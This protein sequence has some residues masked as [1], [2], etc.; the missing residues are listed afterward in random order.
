MRGLQSGAGFAW[1][2]ARAV[3]AQRLHQ[4]LNQRIRAKH[5]AVEQQSIGHDGP[6]LAQKVGNM[7]GN[8]WVF[9][10]GQAKSDDA[11]ARLLGFCVSGHLRKKSVHDESFSF[12][13]CQHRRAA[14]AHQSGT[15]AEQRDLCLLRPIKGQE[16]LFGGAAAVHQLRQLAGRQLAC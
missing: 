7:T 4:P 8:G 16:L 5:T 12:F 9:S 6:V 10:V 11:A 1:V 3:V 2:V 14:A 13:A 15:A